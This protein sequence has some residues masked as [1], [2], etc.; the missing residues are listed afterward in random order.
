MRSALLLAIVACGRSQGV[1]DDKLG[2]LVVEPK[3]KASSVD[4]DKAGQ[5]AAELTRAFELP[6]SALILA[7][8]PHSFSATSRTTVE[9]AGKIVN[10]LSETTA[11]EMSEG[12]TYHALYTNSADY[13][14]EAIWTGGELYLRPRY[15]VWHK[16]APEAPE[17]PAVLREQ[18]YSVLAATWDLVAPGAELTDRGPATVAGRAGRKIEVK[19]SPSPSRPPKESLVQRRWRETR[20]IDALDGEVVL[21]ADKGVP[22]TVKLAGVVGFTRDGRRFAMKVSIESAVANV[23]AVAKLQVPTGN[24]VVATPERMREV[25]ERDQL[26]HGIAPPLRKN[27]DTAAPPAIKADPKIADPAATKKSDDKPKKKK[28]KPDEPPPGTAPKEDKP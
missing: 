16:R 8:G 4:V 14:R 9:E 25:D 23:G 6:H 15:Q 7:L 24:D 27:A 17:E 5:D 3:A 12:A 18:Y 13:G 10:D 11:L 19:L 28:R 2:G 20:S 26:L 22:L 21:D 1:P